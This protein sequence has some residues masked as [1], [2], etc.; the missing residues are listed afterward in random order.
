MRKLGVLTFLD[1]ES[2]SFLPK[3]YDWWVKLKQK[4]QRSQ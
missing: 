1:E 4:G 3:E 2:F